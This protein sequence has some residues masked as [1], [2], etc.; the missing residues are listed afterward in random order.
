MSE[1]PPGWAPYRQRFI[2]RN[3]LIAAMSVGT[4]VVEAGLRSGSLNTAKEAGQLVRHV[5]AVP[6]PVS[7]VQS[8]GCHQL[9]REKGAALVTDTGEVLDLM[10]RLS[11]DA[12][13][14][15][16]APETPESQLDGVA[17]AVYSAVPVRRPVDLARLQGL[18]AL[19][20]TTL[21]SVLGQL[22]V[23]GLVTRDGELWRKSPAARSR[24]AGAGLR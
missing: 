24:G 3:R 10:G 12:A 15:A 22:S 14:P 19:D 2:A 23:L 5:A 6:G 18:T 7:S 21:L 20:T 17:R 4:V 8:A 9:I 13:G 16:R 11:L 1:L